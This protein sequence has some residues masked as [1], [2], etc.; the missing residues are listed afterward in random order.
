LTLEPI[1]LG[2]EEADNVAKGTKE[3][4][5]NLLDR[6]FAEVKLLG[7]SEV[8]YLERKA[9]DRLVQAFSDLVEKILGL[10]HPTADPNR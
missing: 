7:A 10:G 2:G 6:D 8:S 1:N 4:D 3:G 5:Q 9:S